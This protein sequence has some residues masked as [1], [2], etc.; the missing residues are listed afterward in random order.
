[1]EWLWQRLTAVYLGA[2][3]IVLV[4]ELLVHPVRDFTDW[5]RLFS[6]PLLRILWLLAFLAMFIHAWI[7][8]RSVYMDYLH[9]FWLR[10]LAN[11]VTATVLLAC[12]VWLLLVL[13]GSG[14]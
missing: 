9:R 3:G 2:F 12:G 4:V 7:G 14:F 8:I 6:H 11:V 5:Q 1:M 10:F 13:F